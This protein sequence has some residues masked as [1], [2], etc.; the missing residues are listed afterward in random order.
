[1]VPILAVGLWHTLLY[2]TTMPALYTLGKSQYGAI[3]NAA[4]CVAIVAAI[5][6]AFA[7]FGITG[8]VVAVAAGDLPLYFVT[9]FAANREGLST[10]KQ[11]LQVTGIFLLVLGLSYLLKTVIV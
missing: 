10:W 4:Y 2:S 6:I 5:P 3:G 9:L 8:A 11:D 7:Y 1:M